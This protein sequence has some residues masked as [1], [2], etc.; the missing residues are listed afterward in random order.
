MPSPLWPLLL[1]YLQGLLSALR[2]GGRG[3]GRVFL[4]AF[5]S[6]ALPIIIPPPPPPLRPPQ[7]I[8]TE[9]DRGSCA[10]L[11]PLLLTAVLGSAFSQ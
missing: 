6:P 8:L 5:A 3:G 1:R 4:G 10:L 11:V 9:G 7:V 2:G